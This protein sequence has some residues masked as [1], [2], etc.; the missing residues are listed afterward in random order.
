M[1]VNLTPHPVTLVG[2]DGRSATIEP[3]GKVTRVAAT[4]SE[5]GK[6]EVDGVVVPLVTTTYGEV[7][8]LPEPD[9]ATRYIVS[10]VVR[11]ACPDRDD[12]L[13]PTRFVRDDTGAITGAQALSID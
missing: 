3:S 1:I 6:V 11:A 13:V 2:P 4:E 5:V 7:V 9:G 12:L 10:R 8:N